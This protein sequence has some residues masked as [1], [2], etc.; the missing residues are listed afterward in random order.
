[1]TPT[2]RAAFWM[3]GAI[4]SFTA[5]AVAG[6]AVSH[7]LDTF[8]VMLYRSCVGVVIVVA[9]LVAT[10]RQHEVRTSNLRLHLLRNAAHFAGQ[11]LW[12]LALTLIPLAQV[13]AL[14]F[15]S[16]LWVAALAPVL[17]NERLTG[18]RLLTALIGFVGILII[19]QPWATGGLSVGVTAAG[20]SAICFA[21]TALATRKLTRA[22]TTLSILF[23][24]TAIQ[25]V[26]GVITAGIDGD[27]AWPTLALTPWLLL[28]GGAGLLAHAC[29]TTALSLAPASVV[30]PMDFAR[31]PVIA[32]IGALLYGESVGVSLIVGAGFIIGANLINLRAEHRSSG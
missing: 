21:L 31:L 16:P 27:I 1:M 22:E 19:A 2:L 20:L 32:V 6:R 26:F 10:R 14:E 23:W 28:I 24:L 13:F 17:L 18:T 15:T 7:A 3:T 12:F 30:I 4:A 25:L 9:V 8:E 5:M 29:L 11:N